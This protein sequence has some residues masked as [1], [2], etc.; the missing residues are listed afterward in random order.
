MGKVTVGLAPLA[1]GQLKVNAQLDTTG[2]RMD[3]LL[4]GNA[5]MRSA[6]Q[7]Q[8]WLHALHEESARAHVEEVVIDL[9]TLEF[10]NSSCFKGFLS[11]ISE[12]RDGDAAHQYR[13]RFLSD[14]NMLWQRRSLHALSCFAVDLI[15]IE[16]H[17]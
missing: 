13:I 2:K 3:V 17:S 6:P 16:A 9:R 4:S 14:P 12:V 8:D 5:D 10:M 11:W 1:A 7:L 15:T